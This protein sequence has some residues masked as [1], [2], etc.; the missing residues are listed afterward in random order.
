[1]AL[2]V[3]LAL[4]LV[5][6]GVSSV[7]PASLLLCSCVLRGQVK[8]FIPF[9]P[10]IPVGP[11]RSEREGQAPVLHFSPSC[12][13]PVLLTPSHFFCLSCA[14]SRLKQLCH[15]LLPSCL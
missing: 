4:P 14:Q 2:S 13:V 6:P 12:C 3:S 7:H 10:F 1:M 8:A 15:F 11:E 9:N 5:V